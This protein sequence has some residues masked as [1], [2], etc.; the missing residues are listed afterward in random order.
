MFCPLV[1]LKLW[2]RSLHILKG[3]SSLSLLIFMSANNSQL[4]FQ[5]L[6]TLAFNIDVLHM[7]EDK[8][9]LNEIRSSTL[10]LNAYTF[11]LFF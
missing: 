1:V 6:E 8:S 10:F 9:Q 5:N 11:Y 2:V 7:L 4:G 3:G